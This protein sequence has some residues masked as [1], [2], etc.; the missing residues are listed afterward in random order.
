MFDRF[1]G[2]QRRTILTILFLVAA[3]LS[4]ESTGRAQGSGRE[5]T[6]NGGSHIINGKIFFPSGRRAEG[7]IQVKLKSFT[8]PDITVLA[9]SSGSF[10]FTN[11]APDNYTVEVNAGKEFEARAAAQLSSWQE[12]I[13]KCNKV[14]AGIAVEQKESFDAAIKRMQTRA[15]QGKDQFAEVRSATSTSPRST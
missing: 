14:A 12:T 10:T 8:S 2:F 1:F 7:T 13:Q 11:I 3:L 9:D 5:T 6:G 15:Q 4:G